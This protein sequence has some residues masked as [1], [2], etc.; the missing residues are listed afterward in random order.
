MQNLFV[1]L[2]YNPKE[3]KQINYV[4]FPATQ[5]SKKKIGLTLAEIDDVILSQKNLM[6]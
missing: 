2:S 1:L 3:G 4:Q 6:M 5:H